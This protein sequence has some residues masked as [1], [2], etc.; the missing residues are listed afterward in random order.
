MKKPTSIPAPQDEE[1]DTMLDIGAKL[2]Q[3]AKRKNV[4]EEQ[5]RLRSEGADDADTE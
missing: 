5:E 3:E 4:E 1:F 2:R